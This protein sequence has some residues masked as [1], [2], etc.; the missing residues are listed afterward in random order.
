ME[1]NGQKVE[2]K[3]SEYIKLQLHN[4][5]LYWSSKTIRAIIA[6]GLCSPMI[7]GLPFLAHNNIVVDASERTV[8]D[9]NCNFNL[10]HPV[11]PLP[12]K[13]PKQKLEDFFKQ[14]QQ[15]GKL[16]I[17]ELNMVCHDHLRHTQFKFESVKHVDPVAAIRQW[18]EVLAAQKE[19]EQLGDQMKSEFKDVFS[20]IPHLD[21]KLHSPTHPD[22]LHQES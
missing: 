7:L 19:L 17:A 20:Q 14:L 15:D 13:P 10:L 22:G 3:F 4:P 5:S 8:I 12:P 1:K 21:C 16:M 6:P 2:V 11:P 18:I 9:K